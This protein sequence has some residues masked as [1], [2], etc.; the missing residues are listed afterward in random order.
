MTKETPTSCAN[1]GKGEELDAKLKTC[2]A[3][4]L[5]KYCCKDCQIAHRRQHKKA[6]KKRA[7][8]LHDEA[9]FRQPPKGDDCPI[10]FLLLPDTGFGMG[11]QTFMACCG[12]A[13]CSGC[14]FEHKLRSRGNS[15]CPF[16]RTNTPSAKEYVKMMKKRVGANDADS[17]IQLGMSYLD[18]SENLSIKKDIDKAV[19]FFHRAAELGSAEAYHNL[20]TMYFNG[21]GVVK[22]ETKAKQYFEKAALAGCAASRHNLGNIDARA[23]SFDRAIKHWLIAASGGDIKAVNTIKEAVVKG[24]ATKDHYRQALQGY[25]LWM[26]EVKSDQRDRAA[27]NSDEWKYLPDM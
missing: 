17:I 13:I 5:V 4:K 1:C 7:A 11:G 20:G 2:N 23:G 3:C 19:K 9:L 8:E 14:S 25:L 6:C 12:K 15:N 18:G 27:A 16:C 10:C 22:D 26:D 21:H 24:C